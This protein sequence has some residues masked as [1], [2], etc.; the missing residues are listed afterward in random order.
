MKKSN[1][2]VIGEITP[3]SDGPAKVSG[4]MQYPS[5]IILPGMMYG[6]VLRSPHPHA[7][8]VSIDTSEAEKLGAVCLT[9]KDISPVMY[10]E[11]SVSIPAATYR[12]RTVLP[13]KARH[14]GEPI[15]AVAADSE[16]MAYK[17]V[18]ALKVEY[19]VLEPVFDPIEAMKD[20]APQLYDKIYLGDEE[21]I[22]KN[23][24]GVIRNIDEGNCEE[25][26]KQAKRIFEKSFEL[27]RIYHCQLET[28]GSV[29]K[30][31]PD[32]SLSVW[33]TTQSIHATR[34]LLG[35]ILKMP[36]SKINVKKLP[37]GGAFGSSI[38]VN[39]VVPICACLAMKAGRAV[40]L[41]S[42]RE[43]D[44]YSHQK[45]PHASM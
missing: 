2:S 12:D 41:V 43:E 17:A 26:F 7:E 34:Q 14:Y 23:N 39:T 27:D 25:G 42:T 38:Q 40:R 5:D 33:A 44:F 36:L 10:N 9:Y 3:R 37:F 6:A 32:G 30:P 21:V 18:K 11:R 24:I 15:A 16:E 4:T 8:I 35:R 1:E 20:G 45:Y 22:V 31:E 28:K 19:N 29:C 13:K